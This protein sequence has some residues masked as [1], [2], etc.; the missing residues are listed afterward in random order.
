MFRTHSTRSSTSH[1]RHV[2][3]LGCRTREGRPSGAPFQL[4]FMEIGN[5]EYHDESGTY[6]ARFAQF[7]KAIKRKYP[8]R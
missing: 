4:H 3:A 2:N 6:D 5:E 1:R 7:Y 8:D